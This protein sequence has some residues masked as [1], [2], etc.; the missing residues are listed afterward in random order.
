MKHVEHVLYRNVNV[1][2]INTDA[3]LPA[4]DVYVDNGI[5][6]KIAL[7]EKTIGQGQSLEVDGTNK[8]LMPALWDMHV[9]L[10]N[11]EFMDYLLSWGVTTVVNLWGFPKVLKWRRQVA[12]GRRIGPDIYTSGPIIDSLPTYP[13]ITIAKTPEEARQ[14]VVD[15]KKAGYDFVK[16]YNNLTEDVYKEVYTACKELGIRLVGHLPNVHNSDYTGEN[17]DYEIWQETI[18]HILFLNDNSVARAAA[19]GVWLD[20]TFLV[21]EIHKDG[22]DTE[23]RH[24]IDG[25]RPGIRDFYWKTITQLHKKPREGAQK[26]VRREAAYSGRMLREYTSKGGRWMIGTDSGFS[27]VVPGYSLHRELECVVKHGLTPYQALRASTLAGAEFLGLDA[28]HGSVEEGKEAQLLLLNKNPLADIRNTLDIASL[29]KRD[30]YY[31]AKNLQDIRL[32]AHDRRELSVDST[33][34]SFIL[35]MVI[36]R[37]LAKRGPK[38]E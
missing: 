11:D 27:N 32:K 34:R 35:K 2:P 21:E 26:T 37:M 9:H 7:A 24:V 23:T 17:R 16:I 13:M 1:L 36:K 8:Y 15:T 38:A 6:T 19:S 22:I 4:R 30:Q 10:F 28:R 14:A 31:T 33:L 12:A 29:L 20:P 18:E 25:L 5:I 3:I